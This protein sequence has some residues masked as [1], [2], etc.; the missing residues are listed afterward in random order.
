MGFKDW[1]TDAPVAN[2]G[3]LS[4]RKDRIWR[5]ENF[6]K[7]EKPLSGVCARV[8]QVTDLQERITA[9]RLVALGV[10]ALA[11]KKKTGGDSI[12]TIEGPDFLWTI[13]VPH[14]KKVDAQRFALA[15]NRQA[16]AAAD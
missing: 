2:F 10:F 13:D 16:Q 14:K 1:I 5:M 11:A 8:E 15:V 9:T 7:N 4:L 12:L 3:T 6:Q